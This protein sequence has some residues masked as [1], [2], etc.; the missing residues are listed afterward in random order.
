MHGKRDLSKLEQK[1]IPILGD[2][3]VSLRMNIV[4][5]FGKQIIKYRST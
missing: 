3:E 1:I 2:Y 5:W 4:F